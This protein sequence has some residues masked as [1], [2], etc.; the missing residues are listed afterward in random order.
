M[1]SIL[2]FNEGLKEVPEK[3][4][5]LI[6]IWRNLDHTMNPNVKHEFVKKYKDYF[7]KYFHMPP[8]AHYPIIQ[9]SIILNSVYP[10]AYVKNE[11]AIE[12]E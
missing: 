6:G 10:L 3:L 5:E 12:N 7:D 1:D 9:I 11:I 2:R 8:T 4:Q